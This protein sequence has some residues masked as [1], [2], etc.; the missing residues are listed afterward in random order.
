MAKVNPAIVILPVRRA[1]VVFVATVKAITPLPTPLDADVTV[2]QFAFDEACHA[3]RGPAVTLM[4]PVPPFEENVFD[5][6][7][8]A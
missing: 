3:Q 2:I 7:V 1:P 5:T 8:I 6:G 4:V